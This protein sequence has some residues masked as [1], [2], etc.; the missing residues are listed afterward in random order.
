MKILNYNGALSARFV[1]ALLALF[2]LA[3]LAVPAMAEDE[4]GIMEVK[5]S[6]EPAALDKTVE[7]S[8]D[9]LFEVLE[10]PS[11]SF[12]A[13][14]LDPMLDLVANGQED[15]KDI[16]PARRFGGN[17]I[18][19]R[20]EVSSDL[21]TIMRYFYNKDIPNFLLCPAVLRLSGW[22][23]GSEFLERKTPL[24]DELGNLDKPVL[25]RGSEFEVC[26]PDSFGEAY[27]RYDLNRLIVLLKYQGRNVLISISEQ[28]DKS[29]VGRKGAIL[30]DSQWDYFYSGIEGL[31]KGMIGWMDTYMY[32]SASVLIFVEQDKEAK[33]STTFLFKWLKAGWAGMNVVKRT[34]IYDGTLRYARSLIKVLESP[35]LTPVEMTEGMQSVA[36]LSKPEIDSLI[37]RYAKN[38][39]ARFKD[40]PKLKKK[41]YA[42]VIA[43]GGYAGVLD[44]DARKSVVY[45]QKLKSMLGMETLIDVSASP[46]A[47]KGDEAAV[48]SDS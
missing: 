29:D 23:K 3:F 17:G 11:A 45:L 32:K 48:G 47:K 31:N 25:T 22:H 40:D 34:H 15:P 35:D 6:K 20:R 44:A 33:Q 26:T 14:R 36:R 13:A 37:D 5:L 9:Y 1:V 42:K 19:L 46:L 41:E 7:G 18:L 30:D 27:F 4:E 43:D 38:F 21:E 12:D 10:N 39:E 28:A 24:W 16:K 2:A 8:L